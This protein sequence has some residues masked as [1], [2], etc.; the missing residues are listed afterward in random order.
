MLSNITTS[1]NLD[2]VSAI[3]SGR[4]RRRRTDADRSAA[5]ILRAALEVLAAEP[6]SSVEDVARAAGVS[7]QTVYAH[8]KNREALVSAAIDA[9][10]AEAVSAMDAANLDEGP[11]A[12]A[13]LRLLD[14]SWRTVHRFPLLLSAVPE[15]A[16]AD[17]DDTRHQAVF[18]HLDRVLRRGQESGEFAADLPT[19]WLATAVITLG[20]AA[21]TAVAAGRMTLPDAADALAISTL[22]TCGVGPSTITALLDDG[23]DV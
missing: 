4:S 20:H 2:K 15:A 6:N 14:A 7:R 21:G 11:A 23:R 18:D 1:A 3:T 12:A 9:V 5:S 16:G 8:F 19:A 10:T 22:R 17:A 13:L